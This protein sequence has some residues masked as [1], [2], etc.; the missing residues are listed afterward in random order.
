MAKFGRSCYFFLVMLRERLIELYRWK[1]IE[2]PG[3]ISWKNAKVSPR[4]KQ[5]RIML[6]TYSTLSP[7]GPRPFLQRYLQDHTADITGNLLRNSDRQ[8]S[9]WR[10]C[11]HTN[12]KVSA[13][14]TSIPSSASLPYYLSP[15]VSLHPPHPYTRYTYDLSH[16]QVGENALSHS[17]D[18]LGP[19]RRGRKQVSR[20]WD[21][22]W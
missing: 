14:S 21:Q 16:P 4:R 18:S 22:L 11:E 3:M 9:F 1:Q 20:R 2:S 8:S 13:E 5:L 12:V 17:R 19:G 6:L 15:S 10:C 7:R